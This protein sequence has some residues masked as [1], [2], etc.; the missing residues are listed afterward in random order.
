M[1]REGTDSKGERELI[2]GIRLHYTMGE[3]K[4]WREWDCLFPPKEL[5]RKEKLPHRAQATIFGG[6]WNCDSGQKWEKKG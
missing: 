4:T 2:Q 6:F 5:V 3:M 1:V